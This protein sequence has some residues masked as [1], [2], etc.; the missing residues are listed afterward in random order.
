[1]IA[2]DVTR[3][4]NRIT[5]DSAVQSGSKHGFALEY[6]EMSEHEL[7]CLAVCSDDSSQDD[8]ISSVTALRRILDRVTHTG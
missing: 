4:L 7:Q 3:F 1:M 5:Q 6:L 8:R 2:E